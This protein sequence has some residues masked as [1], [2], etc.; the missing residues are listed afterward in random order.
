MEENLNPMPESVPEPVP[1]PEA[2]P[3]PVPVP[4]PVPLF[5]ARGR[6]LIFGGATLLLAVVLCN[7]VLF[8]GFHLAFGL[9]F[10]GIIGA[11]WLYLSRSGHRFGLYEKALLSLSLVI[12]LGFG[13]SDDVSI[14]LVMLL[15]IF[16]AVNLA[17]CIGTGQ[18]RRSPNGAMSLLD[19]PRAFF[20][21][22][23]GSLAQSANGVASGVR[24]GGAAT[25]RMGAV[26]TGLLVSLPILVY[27]IGQLISAD[28]AFEGLMDLLPELEPAE[29]IVSVFLGFFLAWILYSRAVALARSPKP[30]AA[31][32]KDKGVNALTVNTVLIMVCLLYTVYLFSQLAYLSGGLAGILP[33]E[34]T[35]AE[36]ARRG[37]FEMARLCGVNLSILCLSIYLI[38]QEK[39]PRLTKIAGSFIGAVTIFLVL[40]A[41]AKMVMYIGSY[42]LTRLRVLTEVIML[43]LSVTTVLITIRLFRPK[44]GYM[45]AVVLTAMVLG[46]LVFWVD[47]N[48]VVGRYNMNAYRSGKLETIDVSHMRSL[49][50][51]GIPWLIELTEDEDPEVAQKARDLLKYRIQDDYLYEI[52]D[53]RGWN[54]SRARGNEAL[55]AYRDETYGAIRDYLTEKLEMPVTY[56]TPNLYW[57]FAFNPGSGRNL[58]EL[59]FTEE[60]A[61]RFTQQLEEA[62]WT[63]LP[64]PAGKRMLLVEHKKLFGDLGKYP[65]LSNIQ[66]GWWLYRD[67]HSQKH[68]LDNREGHRYILAWYDAQERRLYY[69]EIDTLGR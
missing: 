4:K 26:G 66:E 3:E 33:E 31:E 44:F 13:R 25:R 39:L 30:M 21:L 64:V 1:V 43:W 37:F 40:T 18:N 23:F 10:A 7:F 56:G 2:K 17:L 58:V 32:R 59:R 38:R 5:M 63:A 52:D 35:L 41:S 57:D 42:G 62:G 29:Y 54:F 12:C 27:M 14:K 61:E 49:G 36:Y 55:Y 24:Q 28:A 8:G 69:F 20:R 22:G 65:E 6:E 60:E 15:F 46:T 11:S 53:F 19:A 45:K 16:V 68:D 51:P 67:L 50:S 47:V 34:F 9:A 48:T